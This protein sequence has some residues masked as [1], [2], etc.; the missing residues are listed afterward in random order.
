MKY[1][2]LLRGINVSGKNKVEM[3]KLKSCLENI[4][5]TNVVTY[6]NSGNVI[7][8]SDKA[9]SE[10][11]IKDAIKK[12]FEFDLPVLVVSAADIIRIAK[13]IPDS[14]DNERDSQK[15]DVLYLFKDV[16]SSEII[17]TLNPNLEIENVIYIKGALLA[18]ISRSNQ[19]RSCLLKMMGTK[20]YKNVTIRNIKTAKR[21]AELAS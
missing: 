5:H 20:L 9:P 10:D 15:S 18:N 13:S 6:I 1:V 2:L 16:D 4:G 7:F 14:W 3:P 19:A 8:E 12:D 17:K 21:L 11:K